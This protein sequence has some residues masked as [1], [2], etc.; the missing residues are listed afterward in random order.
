[1]FSK[2]TPHL[3]VLS[4]EDNKFQGYAFCTE[5]TGD[6]DSYIEFIAVAPEARGKGIA[7]A[8]IKACLNWTF[9][10]RKL[11]KAALT[12]YS[13]NEAARGLYSACGFQLTEVGYPMKL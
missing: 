10:E 9:D 13:E 2:Y 8:L 11:A 7:K 5:N 1:M 6:N 4:R 3:F 12:V